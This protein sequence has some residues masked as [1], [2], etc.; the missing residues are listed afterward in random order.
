MV[1]DKVGKFTKCFRTCGVHLQG[2]GDFSQVSFMVSCG[3]M[4]VV[5]QARWR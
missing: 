3:A 1:F 4:V 5:R 2:G